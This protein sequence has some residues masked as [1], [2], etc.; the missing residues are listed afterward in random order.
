MDD[1]VSRTHCLQYKYTFLHPLSDALMSQIAGTLASSDF[2]CSSPSYPVV[3]WKTG[4]LRLH[5]PVTFG[6]RYIQEGGFNRSVAQCLERPSLVGGLSQS[7]VLWLTRDHFVG[8][9]STVSQPTR[10][11]QPSIPS[12]SANE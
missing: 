12:G 4:V 3:A 9:V 10:P 7:Y 1:D 2:D 5:G 8:K 11:T 6:L